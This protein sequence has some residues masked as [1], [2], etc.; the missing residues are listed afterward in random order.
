M[1][2]YFECTFQE[3]FVIYSQLIENKPSGISDGDL[4]V[5]LKNTSDGTILVGFTNNPDLL[6]ARWQEAQENNK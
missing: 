5:R 4:I 3:L 1:C 6:D 2:K